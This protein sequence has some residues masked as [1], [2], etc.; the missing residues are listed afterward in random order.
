MGGPHSPGAVRVARV[1]SGLVLCLVFAGCSGV[2]KNQLWL[3][4]IHFRGVTKFKE[5]DLRGGLALEESSWNPLVKKKVLNPFALQSDR[6]RIESFYHRRGYFSAEVTSAEIVRGR[7]NS[8]DVVFTVEEGAATWVTGIEVEG[9]S[10]LGPPGD[11][12][13]R[14][15]KLPRPGD[16]FSYE[17]LTAAVERIKA[18]LRELGYAWA[19]ADYDARINRDT[20]EA[21]EI[22]TVRPGELAR[23]GGVT[24]QGAPAQV[25]AEQIA[26]H[27]GIGRD[28][29]FRPAAIEAAR[30]KLYN[31]GLFSTVK[32]DY[33]RSP[34]E[35][36]VADVIIKVTPGKQH[37]LRLG[38]GLALESQR[39]EVHGSA[40]YTKRSFFGDLRTLTLS[41]TPGYVVIP[42]VW[43]VLR[44]GPSLTTE[45]QFTQDDLL[46]T[47]SQLKLTVGYDLGVEYAYQYHGPRTQIGFSTLFWRDRIRIAVAHN[48]QF[49]DFFNAPALD[50]EDPVQAGQMYGYVDPYRLGYW[51]QQLAL[52][53]RDEPVAAHKGVYLG[54]SAE[55]G[56]VHAGGAFDYQ[57]LVPEIRGYVPLGTDRLVLAA[58]VQF[59]HIFTQG[60]RGS[61]ITRRF[62]LGGP[63]SHRGFNYN[64]LS[65]QIDIERITMLAQQRTGEPVADVPLVA[66]PVGGDQ[67]L[68]MQGELR[69]N[70][71][72]LF[73]RW[74]SLAAFFD[75]GDVAPAQGAQGMISSCD[76][77]PG[78]S[79]GVDPRRLHLATGAGLRYD[80]FIGAIRADVGIRLNRLERCEADGTPNPDP[81]QRFVF[82][83]SIGE[84]F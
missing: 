7:G 9:L 69:V 53:L 60:E 46:W 64:R 38:F 2:G 48:F 59:G 75:A 83:I 35:P 17:A 49:L 23:F 84:A 79:S 67:M 28:E 57:K 78:N 10:E 42:A 76:G 5:K 61:P 43:N 18:S 73:A 47:Y 39:N 32:I 82:H 40:I 16:V 12:I 81:G 34:Q 41:L 29:P 21:Q 30:G 37:E 71:F 58:R 52:D 3:D 77:Q 74:L 24:V 70:L 45:A 72:R 65:P 56:G 14:E 66:V 8:A 15:A 22:L 31:L 27:A 68:L 80:T 50:L 1:L 4:D 54:L 33:K 20:L 11:R 6:K 62:Y 55:E 44:H 51:E 13:L 63:N 36:S 19:E 25:D 26:R